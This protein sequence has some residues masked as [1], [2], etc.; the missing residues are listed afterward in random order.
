MGRRKIDISEVKDANNKQV[1]FSKRRTGLFKKANEL[2]I[3]CDAEIAVV[4]FSPGDKPYSFGHPSVHVV[5]DKFLQQN[6]ASNVEPESS[7]S[8]EVGDI[9]GQHQQLSIVKCHISEEQKKATELDKR[10]KEQEAAQLSQYKELQVSPALQRMVE[11]YV[12]AVEV[13]ESMLLLAEEPV[14]LLVTM[15]K[16]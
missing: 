8:H 7:A 5:A 14:D 16:E 13:S 12:D 2:S 6:H 1:T 9:L 11:D 10:E 15:T 4:M 3:M